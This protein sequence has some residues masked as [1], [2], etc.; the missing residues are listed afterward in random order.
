MR[1][2]V[3]IVFYSNWIQ[4]KID[5]KDFDLEQPSKTIKEAQ[6]IFDSFKNEELSFLGIYDN[7][8]KEFIKEVKNEYHF[9]PLSM[10]KI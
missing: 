4:S 7:V 2:N 9:R 1:Y 8:K 10:I 5:N 6:I 3:V